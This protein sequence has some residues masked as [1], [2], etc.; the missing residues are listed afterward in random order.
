MMTFASIV[1]CRQILKPPRFAAGMFPT[2]DS[3]GTIIMN[4]RAITGREEPTDRLAP[5]ATYENNGDSF[6]GIS[7]ERQKHF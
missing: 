7:G 1:A 3:N 4:P 2:A 5:G 6:A